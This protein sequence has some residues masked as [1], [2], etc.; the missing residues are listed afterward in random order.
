M[1]ESCLVVQMVK[2]LPAMRETRVPSLGREDPSRRAW[3]PTPGFLPGE[4]LGQRSLMGFSPWGHKE[5]DAT[6]TF[7]FTFRALVLRLVS[8]SC[9]TLCDAMDC[10]PPGSS[11]HGGSPGKNTGVGCHAL[12]QGIFLTQGSKLRLISPALAGGFYTTN[13]TWKAQESIKV[14]SNNICPFCLNT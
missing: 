1:Y 9:P 3:Q 7:T 14:G 10:S 8:Q 4:S 5:S 12:L 6:N 2:N 11:V 13:A